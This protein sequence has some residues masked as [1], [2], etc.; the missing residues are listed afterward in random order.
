MTLDFSPGTR[1]VLES[2]PYT[3]EEHSTFHD[4]DFRLDLVRIMGATPAH[5]RWLLSVLPEP[6]L[7]LLH[8]LEQEWLAPPATSLVHDGELFCCLY[9]GSSYRLRHGR[10][11][12]T[13][14]GRIDYALFR[15]NSGRVLLTIGHNEHIDAWVGMTL[16]AEY[17]Q[18]PGGASKS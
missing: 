1:I 13:K 3:V 4:D 16:P 10:A 11:N 5:E 9:R 12:R 2:Q 14:D 17:I 6:Y 8:R 7:M 18:V 15:A